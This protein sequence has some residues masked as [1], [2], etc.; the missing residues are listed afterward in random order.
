MDDFGFWVLLSLALIVCVWLWTRKIN[1]EIREVEKDILMV[2]DKIMFMRIENHNGLMFAYNAMTEEFICQ[3]ADMDDLNANFGK[4][5]PG[6][7]GVI[8]DPNKDTA[9]VL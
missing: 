9:N 4:R 1:R 6:R 7:R 5:F 3:G 2:M 8:V